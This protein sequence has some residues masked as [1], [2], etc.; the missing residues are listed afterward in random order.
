MKDQP[1]KR[2]ILC[3]E[4]IGKYH[5]SNWLCSSSSLLKF[6]AKNSAGESD[7]ASNQKDLSNN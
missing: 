4:Q 3:G 5:Q 6:S 1:S 2:Q 7:S